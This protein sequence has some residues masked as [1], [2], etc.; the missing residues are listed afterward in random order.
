MG[1]QA[2]YNKYRPQVFEDVVGQ[3]NVVKILV[4]GIESDK[5]A[6]G[7]LF[8]GNRGLGKTTLAK[9]FSKALNCDADE[10]PCNVCESCIAVNEDKS[11]DVV[12]LDAASN[13]G[14]DTVRDV[15]IN[16][17]NYKPRKKYKVY[18]I[19]E[20]HMFTNEAWNALLK[21][22]ENPP[23]Y[24]VFIF[25]TTNPE[26]IPKTI[27]SRVQTFTLKDIDNDDIV[28]RLKYICK[29]EN[30]SATNDALYAIARYSNGGMRDSISAL[31]QLSG[32]EDNIN[33]D[34]VSS[35]LGLVSDD[36]CCNLFDS[37][38]NKDYGVCVNIIDEIVNN[39]KSVA[40][41]FDMCCAYTRNYIKVVNKCDISNSDI[42]AVAVEFLTERSKENKLDYHYLLKLF[43]DGE[44][45]LRYARDKQLVFLNMIS[46]YIEGENSSVVPKGLADKIAELEKLIKSK[47]IDIVLPKEDNINSV[48]DKIKKKLE[49]ENEDYEP[50]T[51]VDEDN[52]A[53]VFS[54]WFKKG[55]RK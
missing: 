32:F 28:K 51:N 22:L 18:I 53:D 42:S 24:C 21:T 8:I 45:Q 25:C 38:I 31:D 3:E 27:I 52:V 46:K 30:I 6:N 37:I 12:E 47:D 44:R 54:N 48:K 15:I 55:K 29:K 19:D 13:R 2:L 33:M 14:V 4:N 11:F 50:K 20:C 49:Q 39:G 40:D 5:I 35:I 17:V 41:I 26:K 36:V 34:T 23:S 9:I 43:I 16:K 7:Y 10:K 1:Y